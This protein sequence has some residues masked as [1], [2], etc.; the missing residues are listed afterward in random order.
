MVN[1]YV[2]DRMS[3]HHSSQLWYV[4]IIGRNND[5]MWE[6]YLAS[7]K[8]WEVARSWVYVFNYLPLIIFYSVS[9]L[10]NNITTKQKVQN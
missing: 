7:F 5:N 9:Q 8:G 1:V 2:F 3:R 6:D 10:P 4:C